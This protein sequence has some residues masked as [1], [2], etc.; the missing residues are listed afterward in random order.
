ML[1]SLWKKYHSCKNIYVKGASRY[2][3]PKY[4]CNC[5]HICMIGGTL[6]KTYFAN[7][8]NES[9]VLYELV[10]SKQ[11]IYISTADILFAENP[12]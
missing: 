8:N 12:Y 10:L 3:A 1:R 7:F 4:C 5:L 9:P 11:F 2:A 6:N